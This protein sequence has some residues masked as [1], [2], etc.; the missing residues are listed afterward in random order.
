MFRKKKWVPITSSHFI[1]SHLPLRIIEA[2]QLPSNLNS[3]DGNKWPFYSSSRPGS[4]LMGTP[5][6]TWASNPV[7][8]SDSQGSTALTYLCSSLDGSQVS[9]TV[10]LSLLTGSLSPNP[11]LC[12]VEVISTWQHFWKDSGRQ[13]A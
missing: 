9:R 10:F 5:V 6:D 13:V 8:F 1:G 12:K 2:P 3:Q 4:P 11:L 7:L